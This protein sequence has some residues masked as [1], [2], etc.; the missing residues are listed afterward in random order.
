MAKGFKS[1]GRQ[2]RTP[3][4][5]TATREGVYSAEGILPLQHMLE[6]L[7]DYTQPAA[8]RDQMAKDAAPYVHPRLSQVDARHSGQIDLRQF[9]QSLG[10]PD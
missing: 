10:E 3:N 5:A 7:R 9:I 1:G 8:R 2:K 4:K 6:V